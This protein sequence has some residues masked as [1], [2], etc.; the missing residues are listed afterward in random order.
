MWLGAGNISIREWAT[1]NVS[2]QSLDAG[3]I[4]SGELGLLRRRIGWMPGIPSGLVP[5]KGPIG[6]WRFG[7]RDF[8]SGVPKVGP[9]R[10]TGAGFGT[11][12]MARL[13]RLRSAHGWQS[14]KG[15]PPTFC[16]GQAPERLR[17]I[18]GWLPG[19]YSSGNGRRLTCRTSRWGPGIY[20][21]GEL[22]LLRR[23]IG[24]MPGIPSGLVPEKGPIGA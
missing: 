2:Y 4:P 12:S 11:F 15:E 6:V 7:G 9:F 19:I 18:Y 22:G 16:R 17:L 1:L 8:Q 13:P 21:S 10:R 14:S 20:P 24:W 5:E 3:Y 23:S